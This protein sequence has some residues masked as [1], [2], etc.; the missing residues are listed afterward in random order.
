LLPGLEEHVP[1]RNQENFRS[2]F[3]TGLERT[4][5]NTKHL[6]EKANL[7]YCK[8]Y[9]PLWLLAGPKKLLEAE[10]LNIIE[11]GRCTP[12]LLQTRKLPAL[13]SWWG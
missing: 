8:V 12:T 5:K 3:I 10:I 11:R 13:S 9:N 7:P 2:T 4:K 6:V 1:N